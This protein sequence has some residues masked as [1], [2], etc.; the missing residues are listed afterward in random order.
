MNS[1]FVEPQWISA[2]FVSMFIKQAEEEGE[3][4]LL[5][6]YLHSIAEMVG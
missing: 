4:F 3:H 6:T 2:N 1:F 5:S